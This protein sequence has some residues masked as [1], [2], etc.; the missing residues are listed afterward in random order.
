MAILPIIH[1]ESYTLTLLPSVL[2]KKSCSRQGEY[3][4]TRLVNELC[5]GKSRNIQGWLITE[6]KVPCRDDRYQAAVW[7]SPLVVIRIHRDGKRTRSSMNIPLVHIQSILFVCYKCVYKS[8]CICMCV[9]MCVPVCLRDQRSV[10]SVLL[11]HCPPCVFETGS[12][13]EPGSTDLDQQSGPAMSRD[14]PALASPM[15]GP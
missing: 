2:C 6:W 5:R 13:T 15:L 11:I 8:L 12:L 9:C 3:T 14:P 7:V 10:F 4:G 1:L